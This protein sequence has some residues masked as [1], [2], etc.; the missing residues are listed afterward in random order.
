MKRPL[1][2]YWTVIGGVVLLCARLTAAEKPDFLPPPADKVLQTLKRSHPRLIVDDAE[3]ARIKRLTQSDPLAGKI[4]RAG[5]EDTD[6]ILKA[7]PS[8]YEIPDGRRLL[9]VSRRVVDRVRA[10]A[11]VYRM[12]GDVRYA[13]RAWA[14]WTRRRSFATGTRR[15][16]WTR[17][18]D[19]CLC[20]RLR[21]AVF[22]LDE[23]QRKTLR[24]AIV[25]LG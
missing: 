10:T 5:K 17:R 7:K 6:A 24:E 23:A 22:P 15:I 13:E 4:Y 20:H 21:L 2:V 11:L 9:S 3:L 16:F 25:R 1:T 12:T 8:L 18:D 19:P 14:S